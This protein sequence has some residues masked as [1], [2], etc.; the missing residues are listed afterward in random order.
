VSTTF[1][2][3]I[4][5]ASRPHGWPTTDNFALARVELPAPRVGQVLVR[6][7]YISVDPYMRGRMNEAKSYVPPFQVGQ[8]L[9]GGAVGEVVESRADG[10]KTGDIVTSMRGWREYFVAD[11]G[12]V[13]AVD[14]P[15]QPFSAYLGVLGMTGLTAW[16]GLNLVDV[17][18]GDRVF[19]S[20]AAGAVGSVA[21]Q[22]AKLR[23]CFV[24][25]SAGS[26]QK[27]RM[28]VDELGFD[29]AFNYKDGDLPGQLHA[30]APD[31][32][33]VYFDNVGGEHLEAALSAMRLHG[34]IIVC[35]A[36]SKYNDEAPTPGP[37]NLALVIGKR[38]SMKGFI[39]SDWLRDMPE[40]LRHATG[41]LTGGKLRLKETVVE[42]ME[43]APQAFLDMLKGGNVGKMVVKLV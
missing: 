8:P 6:N 39:V 18:A 30:A 40:F 37:R 3:E 15:V 22:L 1:S 34:R 43:H 5:L 32:I 9:E 16:V 10:I 13:R 25:G 35:G 41:Y 7:L 36:I 19:I 24:A 21:G 31:G 28:L 29:A 12:E 20:G 17:K 42:G 38:L 26:P 4:R 33:D 14:S 2:R 11:A 27:V 23:G